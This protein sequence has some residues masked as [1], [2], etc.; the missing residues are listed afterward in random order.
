[1]CKQT[2][3]PKLKIQKLKSNPE[4]GEALIFEF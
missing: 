4:L 1:M 2:L 3:K